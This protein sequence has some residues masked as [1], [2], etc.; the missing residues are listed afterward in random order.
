M[1]T[2]LKKILAAITRE[3]NIVTPVKLPMYESQVCI[4][5]S[6]LFSFLDGHNSPEY[7]TLLIEH[8]KCITYTI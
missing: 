6:E 4:A 3:L 5:L 7:I 1:N 2:I 8:T